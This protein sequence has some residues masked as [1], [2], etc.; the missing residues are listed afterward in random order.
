MNAYYDSSLFAMASTDVKIALF[1]FAATVSL[2]LI[3]LSVE[4]GNY[5]EVAS[6]VRNVSNKASVAYAKAKCYL[7]SYK[8]GVKYMRAEC[9]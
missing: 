1:A 9:A 5:P 7:R 8:Y 6:K 3:G 2:I 4:Q